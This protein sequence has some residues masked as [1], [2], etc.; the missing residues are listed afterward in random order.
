M[1]KEEVLGLD[2]TEIEEKKAMEKKLTEAVIDQSRFWS[3]R[4]KKLCR[5]AG[6][7]CT[8]YF[9]RIVNRNQQRNRIDK[10]RIHGRTETNTSQISNHVHS[11]FKDLYSEP[12]FNRPSFG[13]LGL[14]KITEEEASY[15]ERDF[16]EEEIKAALTSL[17]ADKSPGPEGFQMEVY[18]WCWYFMKEDILKVVTEL[19]TTSTWT[20][21]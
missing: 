10:L 11:F 12:V 3:Q 9:H 17:A 7:K 5:C 15:L 13:G 16:S 20:G 18:N 6:G 1:A 19:Q 2:V 4:A 14:K 8:K 21:A